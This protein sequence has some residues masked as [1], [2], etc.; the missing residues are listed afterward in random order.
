MKPSSNE[1][2]YFLKQEAELLKERQA[3]LLDEERA[4]QKAQ[5]FM[6]CPKCGMPLETIVIS[7]VSVDKCTGC[8]GI[9]LDAGELE[10]I[11]SQGSDFLG[12]LLNPFR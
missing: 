6:K 11:Q 2:E 10:S 9:F 12:R 8:A 5:W 4:K 3:K 7:H 1:D